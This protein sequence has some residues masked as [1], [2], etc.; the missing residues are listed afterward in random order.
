LMKD[1]TR[2]EI[3]QIRPKF[4][5][6]IRR[7]DFE[8]FKQILAS[9]DVAVGSERFRSLESQFWRAVAERR[10]NKQQQP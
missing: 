10:K 8:A 5:E 6:A 9:L 1:L 2:R 4:E 7:G 3:K